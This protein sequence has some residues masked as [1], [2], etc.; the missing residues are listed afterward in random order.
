VLFFFAL[1]LLGILLWMSYL[2]EDLQR[3]LIW[4]LVTSVAIAMVMMFIP[5]ST[6]V[7]L[8]WIQATGAAAILVVGL[9]RSWDFAGQIL[10]H[11]VS[12]LKDQIANLRTEN[13]RLSSEKGTLQT[14]AALCGPA[15]PDKSSAAGPGVDERVLA[16]MQTVIREAIKNIDK[17]HLEAVAAST[18]TAD[19]ATCSR[20][21]LTASGAVGAAKSQ[22]TELSGA[23]GSL[24]Q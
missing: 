23:I 3:N 2:E 24:Q 7:N 22:L 1:I 21:A 16:R 4:L 18:N 13:E 14:A 9:Y 17:A 15:S 5:G 19:A 12:Q 8:G 6:K 10:D 11:D 20:R